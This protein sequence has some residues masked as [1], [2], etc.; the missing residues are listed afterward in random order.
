MHQL[1]S[2]V[3]ALLRR[4]KRLHKDARSDS[5]AKALP[6][7]RRLIASKALTNLSLVDLYRD[8]SVIQRKHLLRMLAV[9][10]GYSGWEVC[11]AELATMTMDEVNHYDLQSRN[12]GYPNRWFSSLAEARAYAAEHG[13]K[14]ISVGDQAVIVP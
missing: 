3:K 14:P 10:M 9:E 1:H 8:R 12:M 5:K 13:G 2:A 4:A 11:R 6:I 7:L